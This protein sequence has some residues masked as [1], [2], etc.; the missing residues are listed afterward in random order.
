MDA[1]PNYT[2]SHHNCNEKA[3]ALSFFFNAMKK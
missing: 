2:Q 1:N 3:T